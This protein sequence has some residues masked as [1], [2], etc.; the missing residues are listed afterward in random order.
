MAYNSIE[1]KKLFSINLIT[2]SDNQI[3]LNYGE[4]KH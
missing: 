1:R 2:T 4:K 3:E